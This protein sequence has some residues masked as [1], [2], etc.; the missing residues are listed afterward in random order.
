MLLSLSDADAFSRN[1]IGEEQPA[2][3]MT[4]ALRSRE[5]AENLA[6]G[7]PPQGS[8]EKPLPQNRY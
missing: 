6:L 1:V 5:H 4:P 3:R 7:G 8:G 2:K